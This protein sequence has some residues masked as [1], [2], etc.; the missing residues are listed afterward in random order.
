MNICTKR[1]TTFM[2]YFEGKANSRYLDSKRQEKDAFGMIL[3]IVLK[4]NIIHGRALCRWFD[5]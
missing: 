4:L 5:K 2:S 3:M 1:I